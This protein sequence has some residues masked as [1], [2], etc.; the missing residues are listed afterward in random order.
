MS[1]KKIKTTRTAKLSGLLSGLGAW[2][3]I[4]LVSALIGVFFAQVLGIGILENDI[5]LIVFMALLF[6]LGPGLAVFVGRS[7]NYRW[8][9]YTNSKRYLF[10]IISLFLVLAVFFILVKPNGDNNVEPQLEF[11]EGVGYLKDSNKPYTGIQTAW[12]RNGYKKFEIHFKNGKE[13]GPAMGWYAN[14][15]KMSESNW[16]KGE[17]IDG[18]QKY[19]NSKGEPVDSLEEAK[20]K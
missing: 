16:N 3:L 6:L 2:A 9:S 20:S 11:R 19:W 13:H 18:S 5:G 10:N 17:Q 8:E 7:I 12:H 15:K 4:S 1:K 14:G